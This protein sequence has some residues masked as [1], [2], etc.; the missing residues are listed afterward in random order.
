MA[1]TALVWPDDSLIDKFLKKEAGRSVV[2][3][4]A[5]GM[6]LDQ[7]RKEFM[8]YLTRS[9]T[10]VKN[11]LKILKTVNTSIKLEVYLVTRTYLTRHG[12]GPIWNE[13]DCPFSGI[14]NTSNPENEYQGSFRY[15]FLNK[16]W[17]DSALEETRTE[18][19][20]SHMDDCLVC[21]AVTCC[22]HVGKEKFK[23]SFYAN[24]PLAE[25]QVD[26]FSNINIKSYG[27]TEKDIKMVGN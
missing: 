1:Q 17:Y 6:L 12:D 5:Q 18:I 26:D 19:E 20:N 9:N 3:E 14:E 22:D 15:G 2:F 24:G 10:G 7:N 16:E 11:V 25:G 4:G 13:H 27:H 8:P 23:Y 21:T